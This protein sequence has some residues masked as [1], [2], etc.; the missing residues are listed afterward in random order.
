M[1]R[2]MLL[3]LFLV[4]C[5]DI[6]AIPPTEPEAPTVTVS[7]VDPFACSLDADRKACRCTIAESSARCHFLRGVAADLY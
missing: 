5:G 4:G 2:A 7:A 6:D 3:A 1:K